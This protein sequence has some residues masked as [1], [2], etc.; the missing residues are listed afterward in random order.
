MNVKLVV[1]ILLTAAVLAGCSTPPEKSQS[2]MQVKSTSPPLALKVKGNQVLNS[3]EQPVLLR[4]VN[5]ASLEWSSDGEGH[6]LETV[7]VAI[8]DWNCNIIR[9][10]LTQ[11]RWFGKAPEQKDEGK[12]YRRW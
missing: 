7:R 8:D 12:A 4:G 9:L 11:D 2:G 10:P 1:S 3:K 6:I 5:T